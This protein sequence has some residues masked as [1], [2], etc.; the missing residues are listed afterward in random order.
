MT[1]IKEEYHEWTEEKPS[2]GPRALSLAIIVSAVLCFGVLSCTL[3][4]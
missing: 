1:E 2:R 3:A 4:Y